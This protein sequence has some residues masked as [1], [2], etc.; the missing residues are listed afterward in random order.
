MWPRLSR[1]ALREDPDVLMRVELTTLANT[2]WTQFP[3]VSA[4]TTEVNLSQG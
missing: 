4:R 3:S 1:N 2:E